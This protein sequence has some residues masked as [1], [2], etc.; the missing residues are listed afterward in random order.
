MPVPRPLL[1]AA[2]LLLGLA[3]AAPAAPV[4]AAPAHPGPARPAPARTASGES[5]TVDPV[6]RLTAAGAVTLTGTYRCAGASGPVFVSAS[7]RQDPSAVRHGVGGTRAV[8]D[9]R[10]HRWQHTAHLSADALRTGAAE[11]RATV[12]ELR[13]QGLIPLPGFHA[14]SRQAVTLARG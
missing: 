8:C 14:A 6:G 13:F 9:G 11:V 12:M 7:V 4:S 3:V 1:G 2:L 10:D 5:V